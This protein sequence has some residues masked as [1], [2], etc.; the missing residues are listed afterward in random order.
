MLRSTGG[1]KIIPCVTYLFVLLSPWLVAASKLILVFL[2][3]TTSAVSSFQLP[4]PQQKVLQH[5]SR[6]SNRRVTP[7]NQI[8]H[9]QSTKLHQTTLKDTTL[10]SLEKNDKLG[11]Y[12]H[13][14]Y[15]RRRCHY[16]NFAIVPIGGRTDS[17][18]SRNKTSNPTSNANFYRIN[19][20]Y[21][22]AILKELKLNQLWISAKEQRNN[23]LHSIYFGGGTPSL[24]PTETLVSIMDGIRQ[25]FT[26]NP[27][28]EITIE[29]DPGIYTKK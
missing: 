14:P 15:C 1:A 24:A 2:Q 7:T 18:N 21:Q 28:A 19:S 8:L 23:H 10:L 11:L 4:E 26:V 22:Q 6:Y 16:C 25:T 9:H 29:M 27:N 12:V 3:L 20:M 5:V 13:I 17:S